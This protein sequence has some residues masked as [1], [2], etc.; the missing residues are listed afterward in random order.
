V[1]I[2]S[3]YHEPRD[4]PVSVGLGAVLA[5]WAVAA[6]AVAGGASLLR[7]VSVATV[8]IVTAVILAGLAAAT[9][10]LALR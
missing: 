5:L 4:S 9:G 7:W 10:W 3:R 6:L 2:R 1:T 8:R